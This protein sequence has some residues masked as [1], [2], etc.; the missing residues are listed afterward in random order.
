MPDSVKQRLEF[1]AASGKGLS[2][3][4]VQELLQVA[5]KGEKKK[6][7]QKKKKKESTVFSGVDDD[8]KRFLKFPG[9]L[10]LSAVGSWQLGFKALHGKVDSIGI[11]SIR[12]GAEQCHAIQYFASGLR[13]A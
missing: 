4:E 5:K 9:D 12:N 1:A 7:K 10:A 11:G 13:N 3:E 6:Q 2:A 8:P